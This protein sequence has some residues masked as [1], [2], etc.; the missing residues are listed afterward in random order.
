MLSASKRCG[1]V[2]TS[3]GDWIGGRLSCARAG[4]SNPRFR[5]V[6]WRILAFL[7]I[8]TFVVFDCDI[9]LLSA[10]KRCSW[11][12]VLCGDW[13]VDWVDGR[14]SRAHARASHSWV[15]S[16]CWWLIAL[17][18][19]LVFLVFHGDIRLLGASKRRGLAYVLLIRGSL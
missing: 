5:D 4:A 8:I 18:L 16:V 19:V 7:V 14:L 12:H 3:C 10:S 17:L 11:L 6:C 13:L 15:W 2:H 1:L 9:V